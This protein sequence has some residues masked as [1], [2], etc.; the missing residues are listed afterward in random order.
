MIEADYADELALFTNTSAQVEF[1][2]HC[3]EQAAGGISL[4]A[5][6]KQFM[7]FKQDGA[8]STLGGKPL[9]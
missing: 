1:L 4:Y 7:Y 3:P 6:A 8:I 2:L 5:N 9:K